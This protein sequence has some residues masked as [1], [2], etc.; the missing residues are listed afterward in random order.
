MAHR[1]KKDNAKIFPM[2]PATFPNLWILFCAAFS[3]FTAISAI[4]VRPSSTYHLGE[5]ADILL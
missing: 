2:G 1:G 5:A 3:F 4:P